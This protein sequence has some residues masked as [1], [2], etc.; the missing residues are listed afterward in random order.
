MSNLKN[1][2]LNVLEKHIPKHAEMCCGM[3]NAITSSRTSNTQKIKRT[4][5]IISAYEQLCEDIKYREE[6][7]E[8]QQKDIVETENSLK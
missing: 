5:E 2:F 3:I 8:E 4:K 1:D 7:L 6:E